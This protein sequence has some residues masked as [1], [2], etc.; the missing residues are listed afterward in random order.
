M[1]VAEGYV[2]RFII[3][4]GFGFIWSSDIN[5]ELFFHIKDFLEGR[6]PEPGDVVRFSVDRSK[7][8]D[9]QAKQIQVINL[10][11]DKIPSKIGITS[12]VGPKNPG[13]YGLLKYST[14]EDG[15]FIHKNNVL[16]G[17]DGIKHS[18]L[19]KFDIAK[20]EGR[21]FCLNAHEF[22]PNDVQELKLI[23]SDPNQDWGVR[24]KACEWL[25]RSEGKT[26]EFESQLRNA[27]A[28]NT[29]SVK[30]KM[31]GVEFS[32]S[33]TPSDNTREMAETIIFGSIV[34]TGIFAITELA[35]TYLENK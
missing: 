1:N 28:K 9:I 2:T 22:D 21:I 12:W 16:N 23:K 18:H 8:G 11:K 29:E 33:G 6:V 24:L 17:S 4:R 30:I 27:N 20:R 35:K 7:K 34:I 3:K 14:D 31:L 5:S 32:S 19:Y 15:G 26:S 13:D 25:A 10:R